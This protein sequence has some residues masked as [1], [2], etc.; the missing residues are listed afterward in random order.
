MS[1]PKN[2]PTAFSTLPYLL[3][4]KIA[5]TG[6]LLESPTAAFASR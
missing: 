2:A 5:A 3:A 4:H 1:T 6:N